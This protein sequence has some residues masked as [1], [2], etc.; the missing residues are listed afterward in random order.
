MKLKLKVLQGGK[1]TP[2]QKK[3]YVKNEICRRYEAEDKASDAV[4]IPYF[5]RAE[6]KVKQLELSGRLN[7]VYEDLKAGK[8]CMI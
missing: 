2:A 8:P 5:L 1:I 3:E 6:N 4:N 7:R